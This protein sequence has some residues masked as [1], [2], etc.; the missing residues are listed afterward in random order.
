MEEQATV[1]V[2]HAILSLSSGFSLLLVLRQAALERPQPC[3]PTTPRKSRIHE[4]YLALGKIHSSLRC[5][6]S[7]PSPRDVFG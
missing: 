2:S 3:C 6:R 7:L 5:C 1:V 4:T